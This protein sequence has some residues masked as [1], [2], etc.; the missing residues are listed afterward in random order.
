MIRGQGSYYTPISSNGLVVEKTVESINVSRGDG[1]STV[2]VTYRLGNPYDHP[3]ATPVQSALTML[4]QYSQTDDEPREPELHVVP[5]TVRRR[6]E[7]ELLYT[8]SGADAMLG[9]TAI[10][11]QH[12]GTG[13]PNYRHPV[14][15]NLTLVPGDSITIQATAKVP[16]RVQRMILVDAMVGPD[17][18]YGIYPQLL[19]HPANTGRTPPPL[20]VYEGA[21]FEPDPP[22]VELSGITASTPRHLPK[23]PRWI[24]P[25]RFA[26][27]QRAFRRAGGAWAYAITIGAV[28]LSLSIVV[29]TAVIG[30]TDQMV[31]EIVRSAV[32][33]V[34]GA[35]TILGVS[36]A[37][38]AFALVLAVS[39]LLGAAQIAV[40]VAQGALPPS[41]L[42]TD[43]LLIPILYLGGAAILMWSR[44]V[45]EHTGDGPDEDDEHE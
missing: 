15:V 23:L 1:N 28:L 33:G 19:R 3:V 41:A 25:P 16:S 44:T 32:F 17:Q 35:G 14:A 37:R 21:S 5:A 31:A 18:P 34:L 11:R 30:A 27:L 10:Q 7:G 20:R 45:R 36:A 26:G 8:D 24:R 13:I 4:F 42:L 38:K 2:S 29:R 12:L 39:G 40:A 22:Y 6:P 9:T 43:A